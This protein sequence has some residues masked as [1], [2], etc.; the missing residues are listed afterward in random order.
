MQ[1]VRSP[2]L[3]VISFKARAIKHVE[4]MFCVYLF[5]MVI[6]VIGKGEDIYDDEISGPAGN[7][8]RA[9]MVKTLNSLILYFI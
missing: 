9:E 7:N 8:Q 5:N 4:N 3:N 2:L 6:S 1:V